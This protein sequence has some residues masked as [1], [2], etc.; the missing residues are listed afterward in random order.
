MLQIKVPLSPEG[1][2][3]EKNEFVEP[4]VQV[5]Q[6]EH[7]LV[8]LSKWESKWCKPFLS[9]TPKT[10][11]ET[12]D[13]IKFMTITQNVKPEVYEHLTAKNIEDI[14]NYIES[15][16]TATTFADDKNGK[17]NRE[18]I[19][20]ELIYYWMV[21]LQI[22]FECQKW[23][24]N[25]LITLIRVCNIK[26]APPKKMSKR[27]IMSRNAALNAARRKQMNSKG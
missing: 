25:R 11:E 13:Y 21:A 22:P 1:W 6:L 3:E 24:L 4:K 16:M 10:S 9:K 14:N 19:T 5:L 27:E 17:N 12:L 26:N 18:I 15:P 23:H 8:S 7:S 2:D 20:S